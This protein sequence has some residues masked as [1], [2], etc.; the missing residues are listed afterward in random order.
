MSKKELIHYPTY[1][2]LPN[3]PWDKLIMNIFQALWDHVIIQLAIYGI[4]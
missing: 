2:K 3:F 1:S 4:F